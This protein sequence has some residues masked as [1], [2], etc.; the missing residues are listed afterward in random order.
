MNGTLFRLT[1]FTLFF[2]VSARTPVF[3]Q[4][5]KSPP[6]RKLDYIGERIQSITP[7]RKIIYKKVDDRELELHL[8]LP[9]G[10]KETDNRPCFHIIHGGGWTGMDPSRMYPFAVDFVKQ[11]GMVGIC[12]QYRLAKRDKSVTVFDC[13]KDAR[14][15]VRYVRSHAKELGINPDQIIVSGGSAGG[16]L[17]ASTALFDEVNE[18]GEDTSISCRPDAMLLLFPVIDTSSEGYG[19]NKIGDR[20]KELSPVH[21]VKSGLPPTITF[22]GTGDKTTPFKGA[23]TFHEKMLEAGNHSE[24]VINE[25]GAH[26]YLMRTKPLYDETI[27]RSSAFFIEQGFA[28]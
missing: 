26:G 27:A 9:E 6:K 19:Q 28:E 21:H 2:L 14:S 13:V 4:E 8:F 15:S 1:L 12:V 23:K 18:A 11:H 5:K 3:S 10:W 7:D 17:A 16:H 20:W 25:G 22:H 24:L